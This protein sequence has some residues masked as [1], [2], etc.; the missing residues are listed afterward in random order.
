MIL[1]LMDTRYLRRYLILNHL[2]LN[3][4][5]SIELMELVK[6]LNVSYPTVKK[7]VSDIKL[8]IQ[9]LNYEE[10][11]ELIDLFEQNKVMWYVKKN[12]SA[13]VFRLH[14]LEQ[15][16][17]FQLFSLFIEPKEWTLSEI[18]KKLNIS[19]A[20]VKKE[21]SY[22]KKVIYSHANTLTL[23]NDR[24]PILLGEEITIRC[25]YTG[26][27]QQVYGAYKWP[28]LFISTHEV[29]EILSVLEGLIYRKFCPRFLTIHYGLAISLLRAKRRSVPDNEYYWKPYTIEEKQAYDAF[30]LMLRKKGAMIN[31]DWLK[32]EADF[33]IS[34]IIAMSIGHDDG[35]L[36]AFFTESSKLKELNFLRRVDAKLETI[37]KY[38]LR[39]M[40]DEER[41][42]TFARLVGVFYQIAIYKKTL[43]QR[44]I[45]L[46]VHHPFEFPSNKERERT[47]YQVFMSNS[48]V[49][50]S[51]EAAEYIEYLCVA[52]YKIL[53]FEL[54]RQLFHPKIRIY[55]ISNRTPEMLVSTK[56]QMIGNYF[57]IEIEKCF[58][59]EIDLIVTDMAL[60]SNFKSFLSR[61]IPVIHMSEG[62]CARDNELL[63][64]M[65]VKIADS[66]YR[67]IKNRK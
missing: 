2:H 65:L 16:Y 58:C 32:V 43:Q 8:D 63:Q 33:I 42:T 34:G 1:D 53:F 4:N 67:K 26:V 23:K 66:K 30:T 44:I 29:V 61:R 47:F 15:S 20:V 60:S 41:E 36:P 51:S 19:Y 17:R 49:N 3:Q 27:F 57:N 14:Y 37:E 56:L 62:Y 28:F 7:I 31:A 11:V 18:I 38:G 13:T 55:V 5:Q 22:L 40:T 39:K 46:Y 24:K 21:L 45:D 64:E 6:L 12:F 50:L 48:S 35:R 59:E 9:E 52:Y 25:M 54:N 10:Y